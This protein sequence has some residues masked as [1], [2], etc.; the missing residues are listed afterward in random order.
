MA[1][2]TAE[3]EK[4]ATGQQN[5]RESEKAGGESLPLR[6]TEEAGRSGSTL[7]SHSGGHTV[8]PATGDQGE[9]RGLVEGDDEL[10]VK[11]VP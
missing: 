6:A 10:K 8:G 5:G 9:P 11:S 2:Q 7:G 3:E 1:E 4:V